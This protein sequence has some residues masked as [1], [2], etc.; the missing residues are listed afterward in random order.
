MKINS[1][2]VTV[3]Y[4]VSFPIIYLSWVVA[5][6]Q[7]RRIPNESDSAGELITVAKV[8]GKS[9]HGAQPALKLV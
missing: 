3:Q 2:L 7:E 1:A 9:D 5:T 4:T 6:P 8:E